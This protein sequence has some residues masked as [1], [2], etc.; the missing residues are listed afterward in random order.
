MDTETRPKPQDQPIAD[1]TDFGLSVYTLM[2]SRGYKAVTKLA[3]AMTQDEEDGFKITRQVISNYITG[4]RKV[5]AA[6]VV[7][8]AEVLD[9]SHDEKM[10]LAWAFAYGQE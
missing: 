4:K 7:R 10:E 6:F 1:L 5:P 2:L 8:L 3:T 9:L